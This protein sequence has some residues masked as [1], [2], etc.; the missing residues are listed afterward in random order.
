MAAC[1]RLITACLLAAA[2][3][4]A[5]TGCQ[6]VLRN[7]PSVVLPGDEIIV[8]G[9]R[10]HTGTRVVTWLESGGYN[11]YAGQ[12]PL[13]PRQSRVAGKNQ[14]VAPP[15]DWD[16]PALQEIVDQFV[17]HYDG[18]GTSALC[19][20][21]LR[22]RQLSVHFL[23]DVDGTVYQTLDLREKADHATSSNSRSIGVE[24]AQIG[25]YPTDASEPLAEW[26]RKNAD[27]TTQLTIPARI[28]NSGVMT[29]GFLG[30]PARPELMVGSIQN[31]PLVQYDFTPEQYASLVRLTAALCRVFPRL[32]CDYPH[33]WF[34]REPIALKLSER[35]LVWY[36]GVLGHYHLQENKIDPGPA[37]DWRRFRSEVRRELR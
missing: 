31:R 27:G 17:L 30:R 12:P 14:V 6:S 9:Q 37:F 18:S 24:I 34:D 26:Y 23:L 36:H 35:Q 11:A 33:R 15:R 5:N 13:R 2:A 25:A 1:R 10:F 21:A 22:S 19:F 29:P 4:V 16:L 32:R 3:V 20:N 7:G 8:A 28:R